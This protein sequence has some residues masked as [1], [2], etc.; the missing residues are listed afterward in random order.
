ML[1]ESQN[2]VRA[3]A[4]VHEQ[5][6]R[7][8]DLSR[9]SFDEY[10]KNLC[11]SLFCS[12]GIDSCRISLLVDVEEISFPIDTAIPC[13]LII[14]ELVSNSLKHAFPE[15]RSGEVRIGLSTSPER[16]IEL[17]VEDDGIGLPGSVDIQE[18]NSL[19]LRLVRILAGQIDASVACFTGG[20]TVFEVRFRQS[21]DQETR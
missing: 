5:L 18:T 16:R 6:H 7:S 4:M 13:G 8:R 1:K 12:Y 21:E 10:V 3:M 19:G 17:R 20:G 9:I 14:H 2:R 15:G 11:A